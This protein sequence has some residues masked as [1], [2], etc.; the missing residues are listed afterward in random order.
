L[1]KKSRQKKTLAGDF[2]N[3]AELGLLSFEKEKQAKENIGRGQPLR[4]WFVF[5][6]TNNAMGNMA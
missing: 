1:K 6:L 3:L 2:I 4:D 5:D